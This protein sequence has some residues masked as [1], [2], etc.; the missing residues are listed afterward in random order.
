LVQA[1]AWLGEGSSILSGEMKEKKLVWGKEVV[2]YVGWK[3]KGMCF[4]VKRLLPCV[5]SHNL[6]QI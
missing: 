5:C 1:I 4:V 6:L 2:G 3:R